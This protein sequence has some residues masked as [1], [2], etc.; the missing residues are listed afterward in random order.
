LFV[1]NRT[2]PGACGGTDIYF[3]WRQGSNW[4][5]PLHLGCEINSPRDE[6]APSIVQNFDPG[7]G[8]VLTMELYFSSNRAGGFAPETTG[9]PDG[10]IYYAK[11]RGDGA[12]EPP[13]LVPGVNT[14]SE[15]QRPVL[16]TD[17][18]EMFFDSN[19]P[20]TLGGPL[21]IWSSTRATVNDEWSVPSN[22]LGPELNTVS[23]ESRPSLSRDGT[24][25][26]IA[27]TRPSGRGLADL[28]IAVR[29]RQR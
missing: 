8:W 3:S 16:R 5:E 23:G 2:V 13:Q 12:L 17:G 15:D 1:S 9:L 22:D 26:Y 24:H 11:F 28:W 21:D 25:L 20:G 27:S 10:D 29:E 4:A 19:R 7:A 14:A 18:L 6:M